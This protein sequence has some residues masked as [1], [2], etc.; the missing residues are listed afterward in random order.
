MKQVVYTLA[1]FALLSLTFLFNRIHN[2]VHY[3]HEFRFVREQDG[4]KLYAF[5]SWD[6][7]KDKKHYYTT[8]K[9]EVVEPDEIN[10]TDWE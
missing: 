7:W 6:G 4:C 3:E 8:C 5:K 1:I 10:V 2:G 9:G